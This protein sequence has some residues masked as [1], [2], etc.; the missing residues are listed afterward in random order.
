M[1]ARQPGDGN[2]VEEL[3]ALVISMIS[4]FGAGSL[5]GGVTH[6]LGGNTGET[7]GCGLL[8]GILVACVVARDF[9]LLR[10]AP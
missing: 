8:I 7:V 10:R 3:G 9:G 1:S 6:R 4:G 2:V 5:I